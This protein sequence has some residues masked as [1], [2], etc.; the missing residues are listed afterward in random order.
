MTANPPRRTP[1]VLVLT[2]IRLVATLSVL[3]D[4]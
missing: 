4:T 1:G 2:V 3:W